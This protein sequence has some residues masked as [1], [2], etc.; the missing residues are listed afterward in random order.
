MMIRLGEGLCTQFT[1]YVGL[2][3]L[4]FFTE[5]AIERTWLGEMFDAEMTIHG[6]K[7][8]GVVFK[9]TQLE[10]VKITSLTRE[11]SLFGHKIWL[12]NA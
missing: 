1:L 12:A 6:S 3:Y 10:P 4:M 9:P 7:W 8:G 11:F 5:M 2:F